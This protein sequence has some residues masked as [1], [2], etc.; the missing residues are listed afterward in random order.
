MDMGWDWDTEHGHRMEEASAAGLC[1]LMP[2]TVASM[3]VSGGV[4]DWIGSVRIGSGRID[5]QQ[6]A[7]TSRI[8]VKLAK[9]PARSLASRK[10]K[11]KEFISANKR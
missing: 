10:E 2:P 7:V 3:S 11:E 6:I 8:G 4:R 9:W 1:I 5:G